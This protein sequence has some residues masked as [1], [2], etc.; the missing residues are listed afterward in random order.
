MLK[1]KSDLKIDEEK[2]TLMMGKN[3]HIVIYP[4]NK[5]KDLNLV[6]IVRNKTY[7]PDNINLVVNNVITQKSI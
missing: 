4:V 3:C 6:C 7:D 2:I 1:S 5:N